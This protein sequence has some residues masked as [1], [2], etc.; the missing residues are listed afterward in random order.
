MVEFAHSVYREF[1]A[2]AGERSVWTIGEMALEPN[3][4]SIV[5]GKARIN[6]Q[7]RD[8]DSAVLEC[9]EALARNLLAKANEGAVRRHHCVRART[10]PYPL[11]WT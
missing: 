7:F 2:V 3:A 8:Q 1:P 9:L 10:T 4:Q 11:R 5:P 6:L